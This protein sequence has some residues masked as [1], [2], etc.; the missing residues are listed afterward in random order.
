MQD[1]GSKCYFET[2][3][4]DRLYYCVILAIGSF[5]ECMLELKKYEDLTLHFPLVPA[6]FILSR[7]C[8]EGLNE[9]KYNWRDSCRSEL[10]RT[11]LVVE[12]VV[13]LMDKAEAEITKSVQHKRGPTH[14]QLTLGS[15]MR[16]KLQ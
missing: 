13:A 4:G 16:P 11:N 15:N 14:R 10:I 6:D 12:K 2:L 9:K 5:E 7:D 1:T 8:I 3:T